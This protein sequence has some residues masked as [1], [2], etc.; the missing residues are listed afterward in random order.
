MNDL[1]FDL[2]LHTGAKAAQRWIQRTGK[3]DS[4]TDLGAA[5]KRLQTALCRETKTLRAA[6]ASMFPHFTEGKRWHMLDVNVVSRMVDQHYEHGN[7]TAGFSIG[8]LWL[9]MLGDGTMAPENPD[10]LICGRERLEM[11]A[12]RAS[13]HM[14][15]DIGFLFYPAYALGR[16]LG[17][18]TVEETEPAMRAANQLARRYNARNQL[19][20]AFGPVGHVDL[21]GTSTIDTMMNL[22]FLFWASNNGG[23][24]QL[25]DI[26]RCHA[27]SSARLYFRADGSTYHLLT[28]DPI[29]G[30]LLKRGTFQGGGDESCWSRGQ[31]WAISG[32]A[33]AYGA[34]SEWELLE[35]AE[36][37]AGYFFDRLPETAIPPWD[38]TAVGGSD[39][40][41][42]SA[43]AAVALGC[44][45]LGTIH[46]DT[47]AGATYRRAGGIILDKLA[48]SCLNEDAAKD[49]ILHH[50][51]YSKPHGLGVD[52]ATR[53]GDFYFALAMA[54]GVGKLSVRKLLSGRLADR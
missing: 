5:W 17:H 46:P 9:G 25:G 15:H 53:W 32:F 41:D 11:L 39:T 22:P 43:A 27:R 51:C 47:S 34:T 44:M 35:A 20:Q 16:T 38:F 42:A 2:K 14:T 21:A 18:L 36:R 1:N 19:L 33:W 45:I 29:S 7:W 6:P 49:G 28:L 48:T 13:D 23:D 40:S 30:A 37:A 3:P 10:I 52:S 8:L 4:V 50:S 24:Q 26:A 54:L 31:A 12:R